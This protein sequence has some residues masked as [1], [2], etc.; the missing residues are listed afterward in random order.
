MGLFFA[1][2]VQLFFFGLMG[3]YIAVIH[4]RL[5]RRPLVVEKERINFEPERVSAEADRR[6]GE[7]DS[8]RQAVD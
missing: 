5:L 7:H 2:S 4:T 8:L 3:E 6:I 1:I